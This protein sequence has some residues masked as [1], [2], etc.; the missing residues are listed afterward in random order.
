[1][2]A[3]LEYVGRVGLLLVILLFLTGLPWPDI[4]AVYDYIPVVIN[5]LWFFNPYFP[6]SEFFLVVRTVILIELGLLLYRI[7]G[8]AAVYVASGRWEFGKKEADHGVG[9]SGIGGGGY[10]KGAPGL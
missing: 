5:T 9:S 1:M 10:G 4:S 7:V 8:T 2:S 3:F 6:M